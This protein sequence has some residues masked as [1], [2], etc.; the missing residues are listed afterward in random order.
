MMIKICDNMMN[1]L[2]VKMIDFV[3]NNGKN[4]DMICP[5]SIHQITPIVGSVDAP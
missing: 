1:I 3:K 4:S 5:A 2:V